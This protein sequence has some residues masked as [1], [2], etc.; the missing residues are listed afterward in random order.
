MTRKTKYKKLQTK[1]ERYRKRVSWMDTR[2]ERIGLVKELLTSLCVYDVVE[3]YTGADTGPNRNRID[4]CL[5]VCKN[6][7]REFFEEVVALEVWRMITKLH[8]GSRLTLRTF[9]CFPT[10]YTGG[11]LIT[12]QPDYLHHPKQVRG[13]WKGYAYNTYQGG[14]GGQ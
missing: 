1:Q 13:F 10:G 12:W 4:S 7:N 8:P 2:A 5:L 3:P 14:V 11:L 9:E 6:M